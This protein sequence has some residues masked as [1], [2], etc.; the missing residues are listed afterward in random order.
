M[1]LGICH[2]TFCIQVG[3]TFLAWPGCL[4][5]HIK[6]FLKHFTRIKYTFRTLQHCTFLYFAGTMESES[7]PRGGP[8]P[9]APPKRKLPSTAEEPELFKVTCYL[10]ILK[11][12]P[13][14]YV[15]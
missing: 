11:N 8:S 14:N 4:H 3:S 9:K 7:F 1:G 13:P 12:V 5:M 15:Q 2:L 6:H 10:T